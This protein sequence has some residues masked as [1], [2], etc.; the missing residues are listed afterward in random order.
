MKWFWLS[1]QILL[2]CL[3][4]GA[5]FIYLVNRQVYLQTGSRAKDSITEI[6]A[7][8]PPQ[9][10]AIVFGAGVLS[11]GFPSPILED[12][13]TTAVELYRAGRVKK[14]LMSGDNRFE[15]YNEPAAMKEAAIKK[16]VPET[17]IIEDFAGRRTYDTCYRAKE[18]F[19]VERA[20]LVTQQFHLNR[21]LYLCQNV[22]IDSFGITADRRLYPESAK[23]WW[24][25]RENIAIVGAWYNINVAASTPILG[26]KEPISP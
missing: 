14:L 17:D 20:V 22:G 15:N 10:V 4:V 26:N 12:R 7:K 11:D 23:N 8:N 25:F 18:I 2:G 1:I 13:I 19:G 6:P 5:I 16:G 3:L 21:A 9:R 24:V